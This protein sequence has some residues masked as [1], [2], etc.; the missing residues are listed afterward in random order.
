MMFP[1]SQKQNVGILFGPERTGLENK[2]LVLANSLLTIPLNPL[3]PSLNLAQA[4][5]L[6]GW[7]W[8]QDSLKSKK[9]VKSQSLAPKKELDFFLKFLIGQLETQNYFSI[10]NR[11]EKMQQ[12]LENIFSKIELAS[13]DIKTL[14]RVVKYLSNTGHEKK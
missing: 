4:V 11:K 5:L 7:C 6:T 9:Q 12:N 1:K 10:K 14:Y 13:A 3:H 8:W 2:D